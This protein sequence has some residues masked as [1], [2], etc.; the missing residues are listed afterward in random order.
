MDILKNKVGSHSLSQRA[1]SE[2]LEWVLEEYELIKA[3]GVS[4]AQPGW[5]CLVPEAA[6]D[7]SQVERN[8]AESWEDGDNV[9]CSIGR[10]LGQKWYLASKTGD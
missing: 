7:L 10:C 2:S 6:A 4:G 3:S 5:G 9:T 8:T 1:H